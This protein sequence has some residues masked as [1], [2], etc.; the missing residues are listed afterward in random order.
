MCGIAGIISLGSRAVEP[1][2]IRSM[3]DVLEHRGPDDAGY[4]FLQP[5][6]RN[7]PSFWAE[8]T[9]PRFRHQ[10][11]HLPTFGDAYS[12]EILS[13]EP[14]SVAFG[15]RRLSILDLSSR[16]HQ[17]MASRDRRFWIV[18]NGEVYNFKELREQLIQDGCRFHT[19]TDTEVILRLWESHGP[20]CLERLNGMFAFA[21]YDRVRNEVFLARDRFGV[22]P[23]YVAV[24]S[25]FVAFASEVKAIFRSGVVAPEIAPHGLAE[26]ATFQNV[27]GS[28]TIWSGIELLEP[29]TFMRIRPGSG[30]SPTRH[31]F[32]PEIPSCPAQT[33]TEDEATDA[34]ADAFHKAVERQLVADVPVGSYLSGGMDSGSIVAAAGRSIPRLHTFTGGFD[35]TN[36]NGI[37]QG[38]DERALAE[39]LSYLLQTEH[40]AVVLHAGDMPAA[41]ESITW[42]MDDPRVGMCHQNWYVAKLASRFVKVCLAGVGGDELFAGYPWR[43]RPGLTADSDAEHGDALFRSWHRLLPLEELPSLFSSDL[44]GALPA[45]RSSFDDVLGDCGIDGGSSRTDRRLRRVLEFEYRTF[46]NGLLVTEDRISMAHSLETR[47]PFLDNDLAQ[48]A[49]R[50]PSE[51]KLDPDRLAEQGDGHIESTEGKR[52]LRRSMNRLLP[53]EFTGQRKQG[54]SPPDAN[55]YRGPSMDYIKDML[56]DPRT[57]QRPWFDQDFV[58]R[59]LTDHFEGRRNHRLLIWSLLSLEWIQR[60]FVDG[61]TTRSLGMGPAASQRDAVS[62]NIVTTPDEVKSRI[63]SSPRRSETTARR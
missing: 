22:K 55:W 10:N 32:R 25:T 26:Y 9:D 41:M 12:R 52:I 59:C 37:E 39:Q 5:D 56:L 43:Y 14:F 47:V 45:A 27:L 62:P 53:S 3:T 31:C 35:L 6:C 49:W 33:W 13:S 11:E 63:P 61:W 57:R 16:G 8:F 54:F 23:I 46:L 1:E 30:A 15:H 29:G 44:R 17:P 20:D 4:V 18:F 19:T 24:G 28:R 38:F 51:F 60:H 50:L 40:Y 42:H 21:I 2:S 36:V 48:L 34:V 7:T 58:S